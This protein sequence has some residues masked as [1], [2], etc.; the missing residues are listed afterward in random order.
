FFAALHEKAAQY[1]DRMRVYFHEAGLLE[2]LRYRLQEPAALF[3]VLP[4]GLVKLINALPFVCGDLRRE[5]LSHVWASFQ[6]AWHDPR[7]AQFV[8]ELAQDPRKTRSLR[9]WFHLCPRPRP[10]RA[11]GGASRASSRSS[12]TASSSTRVC[13]LTCSAPRG[14]TRS[15]APSTPPCSSAASPASC[16]RW[17]A[18]K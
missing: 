3:I 10:L 1:K 7:V 18:W 16:S 6:R 8:D 14:L 2:E 11:P 12:V 13:C 4:N 15:P 5:P 9:Q 17:S